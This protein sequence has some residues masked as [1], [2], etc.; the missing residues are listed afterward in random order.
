[1]DSPDDSFLANAD[2]GFPTATVG[3]SGW[4]D[5]AMVDPFA[6]EVVDDKKQIGINESSNFALP[7]GSIDSST[8]TA[9]TSADQTPLSSLSQLQNAL[10]DVTPRA[11]ASHDGLSV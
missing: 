4:H 11:A 5:A 6:S 8:T 1:M 9:V 2:I 3:S 7:S 10:P